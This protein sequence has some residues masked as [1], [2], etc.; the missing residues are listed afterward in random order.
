MGGVAT[1][2]SSDSSGTPHDSRAVVMGPESTEVALG[3]SR[4]AKAGEEVLSRNDVVRFFWMRAKP[5]RA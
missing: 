3:E 2:S 1:A 5:S 4:E